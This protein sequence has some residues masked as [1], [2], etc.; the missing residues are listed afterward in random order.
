MGVGGERGRADSVTLGSD[1]LLCP[2]H[3]E[4]DEF[5][6]RAHQPGRRHALG[7]ALPRRCG[8]PAPI[9]PAHLA[10]RSR[11]ELPGTGGP[12]K[13]AGAVG[14]GAARPRD[15]VGD[16]RAGLRAWLRN[17]ERG[18]LRTGPGNEGRVGGLRTWVQNVEGFAVGCSPRAGNG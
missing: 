12:R 15:E 16:G 9:R 4:G 17:R 18:G 11:P 10:Y 6:D 7:A 2:Q 1:G 3:R 14:K 13:G 5:L 8:L